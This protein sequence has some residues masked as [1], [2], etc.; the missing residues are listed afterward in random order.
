MISISWAYGPESEK[1][2]VRILV[3]RLWPRG[4]SKERLKVDI[5]MREIAP[6]DELRKW[7]AH[8]AAKWDD[9]KKRYF[10]EL[11]ENPRTEELLR[12]CRAKDVVFVF[13]AKNQQNNNAIAL[14]EYVMD[15]L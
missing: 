6:S 15:H 5:W 11:D 9:F 2:A 8:E 1:Q 10:S 13:S 7:F 4:L 3:D 12:L 14:K